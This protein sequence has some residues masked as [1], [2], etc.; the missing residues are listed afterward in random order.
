MNHD[1]R[2]D[3]CR[4][5]APELAGFGP[6]PVGVRT[7]EMVN[8]RQI[9]VLGIREGKPWPYYDRRLTCEVWYPAA[10]R[11]E[12]CSYRTLLRDGHTPATLLGRATRDAEPEWDGAPYPVIVISHGYP[13]N[14]HL[15][16]HFG[17]N[18]ASKGYVCVSIDH[19]DSLYQDKADFAST[20]F[21]RP[22]DQKFVLDEVARLAAAEDSFLFGVADAFRAGLIGYSMGGYGALISAGAGLSQ[23]VVSDRVAAPEGLLAMHAAG[24][25]SLEG[26]VDNRFKAFVA[27]APWGMAKGLWDA[28]GLAGIRRPLLL[29]AGSE[30]ETSGYVDGVKAIHEGAVNAPSYLLTFEGAGHNVAAPIPAPVESWP[31]SPH[32]D[33][34]PFEH[35]ADPVWDTVRMNNIAQHFAS[36]FFGRFVKDQN[37]L[38]RYLDIAE[39]PLERW[40]GFAENTARGL[41]MRMRERRDRE[42][43]TGQ[44]A[45]GKIVAKSI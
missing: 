44:D 9:D 4:P 20:L 34:V 24:S 39:E 37:Q 28:E 43:S 10:S 40:P 35:Y 25:S 18:L 15:L 14:R 42:P 21:N 2:I 17:E 22:L 16:S 33:F 23:K 13:G 31:P 38:A 1:N 30:D 12:G 8:P 19:T 32:L 29:I 26:M 36:A 7:I 41:S 27:I 5:D 45:V 3:L 6:M 11:G